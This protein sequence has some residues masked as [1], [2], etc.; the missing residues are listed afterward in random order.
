[1]LDDDGYRNRLMDNAY[2]EAVEVYS[3]KVI[4]GQIIEAYKDVVNKLKKA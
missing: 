3:P 1:M 2:K 4:Y